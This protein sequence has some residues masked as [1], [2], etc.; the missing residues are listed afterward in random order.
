MELKLGRKNIPRLVKKVSFSGAQWRITICCCHLRMGLKQGRLDVSRK[1]MSGR[2]CS[3]CDHGMVMGRMGGCR[4]MKVGYWL[5]SS[6]GYKHGSRGCSNSSSCCDGRKQVAV[7]LSC[8]DSIRDRG[9][10]PKAVGMI[11]CCRRVDEFNSGVVY[12]SGLVCHLAK[13]VLVSHGRQGQVES[14][15]KVSF[16]FPLAFP[17]PFSFPLMTDDG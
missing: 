7:M 10:V 8:C 5:V 15:G 9:N 6:S 12:S 16:T 2:R 11:V 4:E 17:L 13:V 14:T 1:G 3:S